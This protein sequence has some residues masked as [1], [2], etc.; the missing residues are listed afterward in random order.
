MKTFSEHLNETILGARTLKRHLEK[1]ECQSA[2]GARCSLCHAVNITYQTEISLK[3]KALVK[4]WEQ[5]FPA[6]S[7]QSLVPSPLGRGYRTVTK[8]R[9]FHGHH[10]CRLGLIAP[11]DDGS[12]EAFD[13]GRCLIEPEPHSAI[14]H[15]LQEL[16]E[17]PYAEPLREVLNHVVVKGS[18]TEETLILNVR[19]IT[20]PVVRAANT[21]SKSITHMF[22]S[23]VGVF[24]FEDPSSGGYY[25][26]RRSTATERASLRKVFG[27]AEIYHKT[28]GRSFMYSPVAFSQTNQSM[29]E[30]L[31]AAAEDL[32]SLSSEMILFDL[33]C[34][35]GL[36]ALCLAGT[37]RYVEGIEISSESVASAIANARRQKVKNVRFVRAD[38]TAD[39]IARVMKSM[40]E[41][42]AVI[43]DPPRSGVADGVIECLAARK[44]AKVLHIFCNIDIMPAA[45]RLWARSGYQIVKTVP[46]D[47]FPGTSTIEMMVLL[48]PS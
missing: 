16:L 33:Y 19:E 27:K 44:P 29:L 1:G 13:V 23:V 21:V 17:K 20:L 42:A 6:G 46:L 28:R 12:Y 41:R 30:P 38:I 26:G 7:L 24:L 43:L 14:Y 47:M 45:L 2:D 9:A 25:L 8:R 15:K 40:P 11:T 37:V 48:T 36:F 35:Y 18:Y 22:K 4:F 34:G 10:S 3:N 5:R 31:V 39:S 32:L